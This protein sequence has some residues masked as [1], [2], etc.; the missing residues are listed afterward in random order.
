MK[1]ILSALFILTL[2]TLNSISAQQMANMQGAYKMLSQSVTDSSNQTQTYPVKQMKIYTDS[3]MIYANVNPADS[4]SSF[5]VGYYTESAGKVTEHVIYSAS[6]NSS[7]DTLRSFNLN[8]E[9][10]AKGYKQVIPNIAPGYTL[11][12]EYESVSTNAKSP[13]DGVWK[14][15]KNYAIKGNDTTKYEVTQFKTYYT[16][17]FIWGNSY[18]DSASKKYTGIGFGTFKMSGKNKVKEII[19]N[20]TFAQINGQTFNI[21]IEMKGTDW[22]KQTIS[23]SDGTKNVEEYKRLKK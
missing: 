6:A 5:G 11:T 14:Q 17:H 23:N 1:K 9:K 3:Y 22:F 4:I 18:T 12:E 7:D 15:T 21:D 8:I 2:C 20:S 19:D 10:T 16:D 13:L